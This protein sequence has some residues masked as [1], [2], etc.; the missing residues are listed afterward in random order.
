M[1][2]KDIYVYKNWL[3]F[4]C[5]SHHKT[6]RYSVLYTLESVRSSLLSILFYLLS[7]SLAL[8]H[9]RTHA[10]L[11]ALP[12]GE[13]EHILW[14]R[15][16]VVY[17]QLS[18]QQTVIGEA[19]ISGSPSHFAL[20]IATPQVPT[21][22]YT[23]TRIWRRL[24]PYTSLQSTQVKRLKITPYSLLWRALSSPAENA[25]DEDG[26]TDVLRSND[27]QVHLVESGLHEWLIRRGLTLTPEQALSVKKVYR[28]GFAITA[29][30][31]KPRHRQKEPKVSETWTS[32]WVFTHDVQRPYH[33]HLAPSPL[34]VPGLTELEEKSD[35]LEKQR[36][37]LRLVFLSDHTLAYKISE[38][39]ISNET[40][41]ASEL[42]S[43]T[44]AHKWTGVT[45][46]LGRVEVSELNETLNSQNWSFNRRGVLSAF[47]LSTPLGLQQIMGVEV[48]EESIIAPEVSVEEKIYQLNI[49]LELSLMI[50]TALF[51]FMRSR[52]QRWN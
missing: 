18:Q 5:T 37:R 31:V 21:I 46:T 42:D 25:E 33:L 39:G 52:Q 14:E 47:E 9:E 49:P 2:L 48:N 22:N 35:L 12:T 50:M 45:H 43:G 26:K 10:A 34:M 7:L 28:E 40:K 51:Y 11:L 3:S 19:S 1:S 20:L 29:L 16:L 23:T 4:T 15:A 13:S 38:V 6:K 44:L 24:L 41:M 30:H 27:T 32:T 8:H 36:P 17:D